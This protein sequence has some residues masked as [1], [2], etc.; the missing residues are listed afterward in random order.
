[1]PSFIPRYMFT[2]DALLAALVAAVNAIAT[3]SGCLSSFRVLTDIVENY[4]VDHIA[5]LRNEQRDQLHFPWIAVCSHILFTP[6]IFFEF[7]P[8]LPLANN[9]E[10][11]IALSSNPA[12]TRFVFHRPSW[13]AVSGLVKNTSPLAMRLLAS[14]LQEMN[15]LDWF[16]LSANPMASDILQ[17]NLYRISWCELVK[18]ERLFR[19][20]KTHFCGGGN[21]PVIPLLWETISSKPWAARFLIEECP[22]RIVLSAF[23]SN[24]CCESSNGDAYVSTDTSMTGGDTIVSA[25]VR[26]HVEKLTRLNWMKLSTNLSAMSLL[27]DYPKNIQPMSFALNMHPQTVHVLQNVHPEWTSGITR[28]A[29]TSSPHPDM[30][31]LIMART[32]NPK[33]IDWQTVNVNPAMVPILRRFPEYINLECVI[34]M[35]PRMA[36]EI[37]H[38]SQELFDEAFHDGSLVGHEMVATCLPA[39]FHWLFMHLNTRASYVGMNAFREDLVNAIANKQGAFIPLPP[40]PLVSPTNKRRRIMMVIDLS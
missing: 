6:S 31:R 38:L 24:T 14:R 11:R 36:S 15:E 12:A 17:R 37:I 23:C 10:I 9:T 29:I 34:K 13:M 4:L 30:H 1:M 33:A 7:E 27:L 19:F 40:L 8:F 18:E 20:F 35:N 32:P 26:Q 16:Y 3:N 22:E 25:Y 39:E 21:F 28:E 2:M 5:Q